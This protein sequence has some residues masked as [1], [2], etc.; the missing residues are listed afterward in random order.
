MLYFLVTKTNV[1][2]ICDEM[3]LR[4]VASNLRMDCSC[5]YQTVLDK[6]RLVGLL[7]S[8]DSGNDYHQTLRRLLPNFLI[9]EIGFSPI[10]A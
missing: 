4:T 6:E 2:G 8:V 7:I 3:L 1:T 9:T 5:E 10:N